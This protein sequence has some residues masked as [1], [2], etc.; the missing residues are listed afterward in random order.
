M[1]FPIYLDDDS[2]SR[3]LLRA[4]IDRARDI[5]RAED[6]GMSGRPDEDH[7]RFAT[8]AGRVLLT[9]N[10]RDFAPLHDQWLSGGEHH[11][12]IL[13]VHQQRWSVGEILRRL[14]RL[15]TAFSAEDMVDR[16]EWLSDWG[17]QG[18]LQN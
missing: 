17:E 4:E 5:V 10:I 15:L 1:P 13:L 11:A 16:L 2:G 3:R 12:G 6:I 7:L 9:G 14:E 18:D 8:D